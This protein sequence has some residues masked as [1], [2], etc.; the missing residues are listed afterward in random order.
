MNIVFEVENGARSEGDIVLRRECLFPEIFAKDKSAGRGP[1]C[2]EVYSRS[3]YDYQWW[4]N[5][6]PVHP[7][8]TREQKQEIDEFNSTLFSLPEFANFDA[9]CETCRKKAQ[10]TSNT[11]EFNLFS[12]TASFYVWIRMI[13]RF[14]DYNLYIH[15]YHK[16]GT[17]HI[18]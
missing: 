12:E 9:M 8:A 15:Y 16:G 11:T 14:R 3:D 10:S 1:E 5:W 7:K 18:Q 4:T 17:G 13:A 2:E 6:F